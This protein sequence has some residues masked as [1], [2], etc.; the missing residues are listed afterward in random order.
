MKQPH[1]LAA[2]S[3]ASWR[4][5]V[6]TLPLALSLCG[7]AITVT[8]LRDSPPLPKAAIASP[9]AVTEAHAFLEQKTAFDAFVALS[10]DQEITRWG[11][12]DLP[13]NTHLVRKSLISALIGIAIDKR[14]MRLDDSLVTLG[15]DEPATP[16]TP[17]ERSATVRQ[18][19]QSRSGVYIHAAGET[20]A[21]RDGRPA[22]GQYAPGEHFYYNNW[23]FNVLGAIFERQ[24]GMSIGQALYEWIA[25]PT[26]MGS[27]MP[28]YVIY[29]DAD[30]SQYRQ[31]V[32]FMS[33]AD[34]A[35]FGALYVQGGRWNGKQVI[36][37]AWVTESLMPYSSV[38]EP[39][40]F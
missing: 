33:A 27:F 38:T 7:C 8:P 2:S 6:T 34:L 39:R 26:G 20:Q 36:P 21:M 19:L 12:A 40:P 17:R 13:I 37:E 11:E 4:R 15:I 5:S 3:L 1:A 16:L 14:L 30:R 18:L 32:I 24:T 25:I 10:G 29:R 28:E 9:A 31:F 22:R 35:R 23:D